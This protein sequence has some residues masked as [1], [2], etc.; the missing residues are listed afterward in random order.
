MSCAL[1]EAVWQEQPI[2]KQVADVAKKPAPGRH[3]GKL[4]RTRHWTIEKS[5]K[6]SLQSHCDQRVKEGSLSGSACG[7]RVDECSGEMNTFV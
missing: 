6:C 5:L 2:E 1:K 3:S 7:K 4:R